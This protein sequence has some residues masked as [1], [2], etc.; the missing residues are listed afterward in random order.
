MWRC[1]DCMFF[2]SFPVNIFCGRTDR[3]VVL[4]Q[5]ITTIYKITRKVQEYPKSV[6]DEGD[7]RR[8]LICGRTQLKIKL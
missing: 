4:K 3:E 2:K 5:H 8:D 7:P 1:F 6:K